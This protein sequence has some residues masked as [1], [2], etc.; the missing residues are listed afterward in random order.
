MSDELLYQKQADALT[1][2]G[3][4]IRYPDDFYM[5]AR[6]EAETS[7]EIALFVREFVRAKLFGA[8]S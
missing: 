7:I 1:I 3:V 6:E 2:Y 5:P 8:G 4:E